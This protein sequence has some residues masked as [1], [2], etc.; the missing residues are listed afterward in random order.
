MRSDEPAPAGAV[1][2]VEPELQMAAGGD[3]SAW[4]MSA[5]SVIGVTLLISSEVEATLVA[6]ILTL[7]AIFQI[8]QAVIWVAVAIATVPVLW[9]AAWLVVRMRYV[10][11]C[12]S[13]GREV[14]PTT[15][16]FAIFRRKQ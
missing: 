8:P 14:G 11:S 1:S 4:M 7:G 12:L 5:M 3:R 15:Q 9:L 16:G 2:A 6:T 10:E 13:E